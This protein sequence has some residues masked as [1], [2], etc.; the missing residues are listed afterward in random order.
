[1]PITTKGKHSVEMQVLRFPTAKNASAYLAAA[2]AAWPHE[3]SA[4]VVARAVYVWYS[5]SNGRKWFFAPCH[6][7]LEKGAWE[8]DLAVYT[9]TGVFPIDPTKVNMKP[10][11]F[12]KYATLLDLLA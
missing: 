5:R 12:V 10:E 4:V 6:K 11:T 2:R 1:M 7:C 9:K 8:A 3:S